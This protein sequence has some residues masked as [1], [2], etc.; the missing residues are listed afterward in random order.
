MFAGPSRVGSHIRNYTI[1]SRKGPNKGHGGER[2][3]V[4]KLIL[5]ICTQIHIYIC[6]YIYA[7]FNVMLAFKLVKP[8]NVIHDDLI[9]LV[10]KKSFF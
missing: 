6:T 4:T 10:Y 8:S 9:N 3:D 7:E 5:T 1:S 2:N